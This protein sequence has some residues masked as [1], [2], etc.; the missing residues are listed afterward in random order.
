[1]GAAALRTIYKG[2]VPNQAQNEQMAR[3]LMECEPWVPAS[4]HDVYEI[5]ESYSLPQRAPQVAPEKI[6]MAVFVTDGYLLS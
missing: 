1:V 2:N 5:L 3:A 6:T 4:V